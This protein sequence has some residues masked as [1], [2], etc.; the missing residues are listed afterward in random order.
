MT[1]TYIL[2]SFL[3]FK[4][5]FSVKNHVFR[6]HISILYHS[7][8]I[9]RSLGQISKHL[10]LPLNTLH[11][12]YILVKFVFIIDLNRY[13]ETSLNM[14]G[15]AYKRICSLTQHTTHPII[16]QLSK[17]QSTR[18]GFWSQI[19]FWGWGILSRQG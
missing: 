14:N 2:F 19:N 11:Y 18:K 9:Q 5:H 8:L 7:F 12:R 4:A 17:I 6:A 1:K 10:N 16:I 13:S 3:A 15:L